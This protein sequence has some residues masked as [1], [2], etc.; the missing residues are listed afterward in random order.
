MTSTF[1]AG[2]RYGFGLLTNV[3]HSADGVGASTP[4]SSSSS[5]ST[6]FSSGLCTTCR[7]RDCVCTFP[8]RAARGSVGAGLPADAPDPAAAKAGSPLATNAAATSAATATASRP[9]L[10]TARLMVPP[11]DRPERRSPQHTTTPFDQHPRLNP[12]HAAPAPARS[13]RG[14]AYGGAAGPD[15]DRRRHG[16]RSVAFLPLLAPDAEGGRGEGREPGRRDRLA[17]HLAPAVA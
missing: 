14:L 9:P 1:G 8:G 4:R 2:F 5:D 13:G 3:W 16:S 17:A 11:W 10:R 12:R 6:S 7:G 15:R